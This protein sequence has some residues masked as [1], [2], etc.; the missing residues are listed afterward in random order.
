MNNDLNRAIMHTED[1]LRRTEKI[2]R[3]FRQVE[4]CMQVIHDQ[5]NAIDHSAE[6]MGVKR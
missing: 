2:R 5:Q 1:V 3:L 6:R 4:Q